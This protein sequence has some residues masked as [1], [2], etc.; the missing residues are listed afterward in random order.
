[1]SWYVP[2][3]L[4]VTSARS[5]ILGVVVLAGSA[6]AVSMFLLSPAARARLRSSSSAVLLN[7]LPAVLFLATYAVVLV[8]A[9]TRDAVVD[10]R[11]LSPVYVP[12]SF[13]LLELAHGLFGPI[14][15]FT[16]ATAKRIPSLLLALW[17]CFPFASV[18]RATIGRVRNGAGGL[19]SSKWR[20]SETVAQA[21]QMASI[22]DKVHIY[23]N[24]PDALWELARVNARELPTRSRVN[25]SDLRGRW[26][27]D[28]VSVLVWFDN[29]GWRDYVLSVE[30]LKKVADIE[31]IAHLND[32]S[33]YRV[34]LRDTAAATIQ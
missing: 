24:G 34:T 6:V 25:L 27:P 29:Y 23:S 32:G 14:R 33:I 9:A 10:T 5:L 30:E 15:H 21:K 7:H 20:K 16:A 2:V 11:T 13:I 3:D 22:K 31:E 1:L 19:N 8:L 28:S 18:V 4:V 12:L 17:L 26:P